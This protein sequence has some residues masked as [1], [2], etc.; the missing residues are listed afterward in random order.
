MSKV[1]EVP[2]PS[3]GLLYPKDSPLYKKEVVTI[4][5]MTAS[6]EDLLSSKDLWKKGK[7]IDELLK[8]CVTDPIAK[9][10]LSDL[11]MG[12]RNVLIVSIRVFSL[13]PEYETI[14]TCPQCNKKTKHT[15]DLS[16]IKAVGICVPEEVK[17]E[18]NTEK[19]K[20]DFEALKNEFSLLLPKS[21]KNITFKLL[22]SKESREIEMTND[23]L[24]E[25]SNSKKD[26]MITIR[27]KK[28]ITSVDGNTD[29]TTIAR[30]VETMP[31]LDSTTFRKYVDKIQPDIVIDEVVEC[32]E[33][34]HKEVVEMPRLDASFFWLD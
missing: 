19:N 13:G 20:I 7:F 26:Q 33:C 1:I 21:N 18:D 17:E 3:R 23:K 25:I 10:N 32:E 29:G 4:K 30:F 12:D 2:L 6:E 15:F 5:E 9:N 27:M 11:L 14:F 22:T 28:M 31:V 8:S 34:S 24:K 16:K